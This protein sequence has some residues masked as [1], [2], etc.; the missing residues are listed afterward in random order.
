MQVNRHKLYDNSF[1]VTCNCCLSSL[2]LMVHLQYIFWGHK[3]MA[4]RFAACELL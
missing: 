3:Y 1:Y 2:Q 4:M